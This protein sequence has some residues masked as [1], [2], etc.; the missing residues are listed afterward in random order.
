[1]SAENDTLDTS[2]VSAVAERVRTGLEELHNH[3]NTQI[4]TVEA[5]EGALDA[6]LIIVK[7]EKAWMGLRSVTKSFCNGQILPKIEEAIA[8]LPDIHKEVRH[9]LSDLEE[10]L[11]RGDVFLVGQHEIS[12]RDAKMTSQALVAF[13]NNQGSSI[14][15]FLKYLAG[16]HD[17]IKEFGDQTNVSEYLKELST[18]QDKYREIDITELPA[19]DPTVDFVS[20]VREWNHMLD[21]LSQLKSIVETI[22]AVRQIQGAKQFLNERKRSYGEW[23]AQFPNYLELLRTVESLI[24]PRISD[25][26]DSTPL[27]E[28]NSEALVQLETQIKSAHLPQL[29]HVSGTL[30]RLK[31]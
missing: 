2:Q 12:R 25:L 10:E 23:S 5:T 21:L 3:L 11:Q 24:R 13:Q 7:T 26:S 20:A 4:N 18:L 17:R 8:S 30:R 27:T 19:R 31:P 14:Y 29:K 28:V 6:K 1:M 16:N 15:N 9:I 22:I